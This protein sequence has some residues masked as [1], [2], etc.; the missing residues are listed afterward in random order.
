[1]L[2]ICILPSLVLGS[3]WEKHMVMGAIAKASKK[4]IFFIV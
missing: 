1:M 3:V 4:G 2:E